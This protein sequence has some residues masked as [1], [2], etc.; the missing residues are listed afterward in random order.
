MLNLITTPIFYVNSKPHVGHLY[1]V[2]LA[3]AVRRTHW[4]LG[5]KAVL[6]T[7]TDEHGMK[8]VQSVLALIVGFNQ[9]DGCE[10]VL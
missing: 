10:G 3:D 1:T 8:V 9:W 2:Y 5:R 6:S 7:G 4:L